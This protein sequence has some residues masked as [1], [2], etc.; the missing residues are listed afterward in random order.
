M[1]THLN[2]LHLWHTV[3]NVIILRGFET[4]SKLYDVDHNPTITG[5]ISTALLDGASVCSKKTIEKT[6]LIVTTFLNEKYKSRLQILF[7]MYFLN[8][9]NESKNAGETLKEIINYFQNKQ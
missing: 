1:I 4:Y 9:I 6:Y 8:I 3:P 2:S 7:D 5:L